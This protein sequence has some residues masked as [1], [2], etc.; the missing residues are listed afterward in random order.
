[1]PD[2]DLSLKIPDAYV[3]RAIEAFNGLA[4]KRIELM[5]HGDGGSPENPNFNGNWSFTIAPK[6]ESENL[7]QFGERFLRELGIAALRLWDYAEDQD[8]YRGEVALI[9]PASQD[10]P[11]DAI[12][13]L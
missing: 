13:Q 4:G 3:S 8:R 12:E 2:V 11:D 10:V 5:A 7:K 6:G 9:T 1:M